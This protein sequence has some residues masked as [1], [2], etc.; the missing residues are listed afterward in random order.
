MGSRVARTVGLSAFA[1]VYGIPFVY[2]IATS[3]KSSVVLFDAP[4]DLTFRPTL[5]AY[6]NV[7]NAE[8]LSALK[9]SAIVAFG[10]TFLTVA[11]A[12]PAAYWLSRSRSW[13]ID[14]GLSLLILL[15]MVPQANNVIPL[16]IIMA[17][18][19]LIGTLKSLILADT[20]LLLPFS[21]IILRPFFLSIPKE[22]DEAARVDGSSSTRIFFEVYLPLA[23]NGV[24]TA[25]ILVWVIAWG[26]F[27]YAITFITSSSRI[28]VSGLLAQ[29][30]SQYGI[31]WDHLMAVS[32]LVTLP[33]L[34]IF[35]FAQRFLREG[36]A[37]GAT[38]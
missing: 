25:A 33:V 24:L 26:E 11:L 8:L 13:L 9:N 3:L 31:Q 37:L 22:I 23:R 38:K 7:L 1:L 14:L 20:A 12:V 4:A 30:V 5:T 21:I 28:P 29:Q 34:I 15:Q 16:F 36:L 19:G 10:T 2:L 27:L 17:D 6:R 32:A 18:W 35:L